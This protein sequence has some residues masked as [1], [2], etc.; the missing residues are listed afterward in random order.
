[1]ELS[2]SDYKK[3]L[4]FYNQTIPRSDRLLKKAGEQILADK[5]CSCIK[6][7]SPRNDEPRSIGICTKNIFIRRN[8]KRSS[9][10]CKKKRQIKGLT[11]TQKIYFN[12]K[13]KNN[14]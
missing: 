8:M 1:M 6:K 5:L 14:K 13:I 10:S 4:E 12:K 9:F 11:K 3:I 2:N 7:V